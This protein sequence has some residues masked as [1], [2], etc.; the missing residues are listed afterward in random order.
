MLIVKILEDYIV[1]DRNDYG[2]V[3]TCWLIFWIVL[4]KETG[5]LLV[6]FGY[7]E[8]SRSLVMLGIKRI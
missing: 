3:G 5:P 1:D 6:F 2:Q 7:S 4:R 8:T